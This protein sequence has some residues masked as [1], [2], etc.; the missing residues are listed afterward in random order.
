LNI[1]TVNKA[2]TLINRTANAFARETLRIRTMAYDSNHYYVSYSCGLLAS[3]LQTR[4]IVGCLDEWGFFMST[5]TILI[6]Y[7]GDGLNTAG[8]N[9][10]FG[11]F[12]CLLAHGVNFS[13]MFIS[14]Y[15]ELKSTK[16]L[17]IIYALL[18][19]DVIIEYQ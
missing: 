7:E 15:E 9:P 6:N 5:L 1:A 10:N 17:K 2:R 19:F 8:I 14:H 16:G 4:N 13:V 3:I 12:Y 11:N 18:K